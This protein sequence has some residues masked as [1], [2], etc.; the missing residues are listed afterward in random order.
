MEQSRAVMVAEDGLDGIV[1][2]RDLR[3][4]SLYLGAHV[5]N[6][7]DVDALVMVQHLVEEAGP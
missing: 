6:A 4:S 1:G 2:T 3:P 7:G 5:A